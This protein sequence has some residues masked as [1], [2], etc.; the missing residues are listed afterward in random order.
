[1]KY[2]FPKEETKNAGGV[3]IRIARAKEDEVVKND[4]G[5]V[6]ILLGVSESEK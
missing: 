3:R 1:M 5:G 2:V 4:A 6:E